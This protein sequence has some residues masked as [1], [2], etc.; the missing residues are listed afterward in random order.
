MNGPK[1]WQVKQVGQVLATL[2]FC[3]TTAIFL[4][5]MG[6]LLYYPLDAT[7]ENLPQ[8]VN[9]SL[10]QLMHNYRVLLA[11]LQLPWITTLH[12]PDFFSSAAG[13]A[14]FADVKKL[15][16]LNDVLMLLSAF[17][18]IPTLHRWRRTQ[19][20]WRLHHGFQLGAILPILIGGLA[21][22]NFDQFFVTF[23]HLFFR[24]ATNW[25]FDPSLDPIINVLPEVFFMHCFLVFFILFEAMMLSG[26]Y[27]SRF[28]KK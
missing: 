28:K 14:H 27:C 12:F 10:A 9:L 4:T 26:I 15:F 8:L 6:T 2:L 19:Q 13:L 21:A 17:V 23:H 11:Y 5:I 16:I 25:L 18:A 22:T 20:L 7:R 1:L 3:L 24:N